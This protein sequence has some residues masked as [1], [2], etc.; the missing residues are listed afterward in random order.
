MKA[1]ILTLALLFSS[2]LK[3]DETLRTFTKSVTTSAT[4]IESPG[5]AASTIVIQNPASNSASIFVG[6]D[7]TVTTSGATRGLEVPVGGSINFEGSK[8][9]GGTQ[10]IHTGKFFVIAASSQTVVVGV[11]QR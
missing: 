7:N 3:A 2:N 10:F 9:N 5:A 11:L 8:H 4:A 6:G 1:F